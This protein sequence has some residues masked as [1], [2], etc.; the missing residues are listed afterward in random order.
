MKCQ[1]CSHPQREAIDLALLAENRTFANL[2]QQYGL[3]VSSLFRHKKHLAENMRRA[4]HRLQ[5]SQDQACLLKLNTILD[6]VQGAI[7]T[8]KA[9]GNVDQVLKG[10]HVASRLIYHINQMDVPLDLETTYRLISSPLSLNQKQKTAS[11]P[12]ASCR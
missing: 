1:T 11:P 6:H 12:E 2:S 3:S 5:E 10:S 8:A 7:Q 9:Q 4:C